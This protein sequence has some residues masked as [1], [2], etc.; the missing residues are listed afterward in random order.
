M[1]REVC[2]AGALFGTVGVTRVV[3]ML[4]LQVRLTCQTSQRD[5]MACICL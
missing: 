2:R 1:M 4:A 5:A 3:H